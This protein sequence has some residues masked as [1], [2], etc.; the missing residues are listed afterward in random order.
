MKFL[1]QSML[2]AAIAGLSFSA[3]ADVTVYG[4]TFT[5]GAHTQAT[6][7]GLFTA[8]DGVAGLTSGDSFYVRGDMYGKVDP[9]FQTKI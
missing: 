1:K 8:D 5:N 9:G 6:A 3:A 2:A 4:N 7:L